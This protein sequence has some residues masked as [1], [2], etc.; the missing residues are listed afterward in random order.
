MS[1]V[2]DGKIVYFDNS[3][4]GS[5]GF[6]DALGGELRDIAASPRKRVKGARYELDPSRHSKIISLQYGSN[7]SLL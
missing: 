2:S 7:R 6:G 3:Q 1:L 5:C 4:A